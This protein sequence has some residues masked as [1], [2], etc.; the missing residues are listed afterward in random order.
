MSTGDLMCWSRTRVTCWI[1]RST[2]A[3]VTEVFASISRLATDSWV[4]ADRTFQYL[5]LPG[6]ADGTCA[7]SATSSPSDTRTSEKTRVAMATCRGER[8]DDGR[9]DR[10]SYGRKFHCRGERCLEV[11]PPLRR[12]PQVSLDGSAATSEL[13]CDLVDG[14]A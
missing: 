9:V 13:G 2:V 1:N 10:R 12:L 14:P 11:G 7:I 5:A 6:W 4:W 8:G 3:G